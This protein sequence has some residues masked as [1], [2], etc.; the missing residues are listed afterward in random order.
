MSPAARDSA[1]RV[2]RRSDTGAGRASSSRPTPAGARPRDRRCTPTARTSA[3]APTAE[4]R[5][6]PAGPLRAPPAASR[7]PARAPRPPARPVPPRRWRWSFAGSLFIPS[8]LLET[9]YKSASR[10]RRS[11]YLAA[12]SFWNQ[13]NRS[14]W[15]GLGG[16]GSIK[17]PCP[18]LAT[19]ADRH[20]RRSTRPPGSRPGRASRRSSLG[21]SAWLPAVP[22]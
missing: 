7:A 21:R 15:G 19:P 11:Y 5:D 16:K 4:R 8:I 10:F 17:R 12:R 9:S 13:G 3:R 22:G 18:W 6:R 1:P 20:C 14:S 2:R